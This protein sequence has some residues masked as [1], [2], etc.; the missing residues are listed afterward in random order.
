MINLT[1]DVYSVEC[2]ENVKII[3]KKRRK[4]IKKKKIKVREKELNNQVS[5]FFETA[6]L[7][8]GVC[9]VYKRTKRT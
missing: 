2:I 1:F 6:K 9:L 4:R 5:F 8:L 7:K 3:K